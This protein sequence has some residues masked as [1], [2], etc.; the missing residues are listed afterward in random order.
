MNFFLCSS[1]MRVIQETV[2][3]KKKES[4]SFFRSTNTGQIREVCVCALG[5]DTVCHFSFFLFSRSENKTFFTEKRFES[6]T[7]RKS[8]SSIE[9]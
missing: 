3:F 2:F 7:K 9:K 6:S 4:Y 8:S 1:M 5:I